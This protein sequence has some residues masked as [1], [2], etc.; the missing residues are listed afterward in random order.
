MDSLFTVFLLCAIVLM[1]IHES[2]SQTRIVGGRSI[3][4]EQAPFVVSLQYA[5]KHFCGGE[6]W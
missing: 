1:K 3:N 4:I 2:V 5:G 6:V